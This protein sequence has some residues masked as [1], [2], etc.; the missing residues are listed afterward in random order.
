MFPKASVL[1]ANNKHDPQLLTVEPTENPQPLHKKTQRTL[2]HH[3][4]SR[5]QLRKK[6]KQK[7][8]HLLAKVVAFSLL[9]IR[10]IRRKQVMQKKGPD[11]VSL[12]CVFQSAREKMQAS[13]AEK[14][15]LLLAIIVDF[16][17]LEIRIRKTS[18]FFSRSCCFQPA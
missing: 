2:D 17:A 3:T 9:D 10:I 12:S 11:F 13:N 15:A 5:Q 4:D 14:R 18:I 1:F 6:K 7:T 8:Y 16:S